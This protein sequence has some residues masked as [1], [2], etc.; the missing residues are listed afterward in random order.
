MDRTII[1]ILLLGACV[2]PQ[3]K[4]QHPH[5]PPPDQTITVMAW[6]IWHGGREDGEHVGVQ[7]T[8]DV[9]R[10]SGADLVAMQ[11][12]YGS[13][14]IIS[15]ALGFHFVPRGTNVSIHSRFPVLADVSVFEE[16]KCVGAVVELP[17]GTPLAFYSIWLPYSEDIWLPE[18]RAKCD[19]DRMLAACQVS[20]DDLK[21]IL[22]LMQAKLHETGYSNIPVIVA[23]DFNSMSHLDYTPAAADQFDGWV[24]NWPTSHVIHDGGFADSYRAVHPTVNRLRDRTWSPRFTEQEQERIDF[25]YYRGD[26]SPTTAQVV[27]THANGFPSDHAAVVTDFTLQRR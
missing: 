26:L 18:I 24:L 22:G 13:G 20:A 1:L 11:E 17:D 19:E 6:N 5:Q 12:T 10:D 14:E 3:A 25:I 8:I 27:Q 4:P 7:K 2:Q 16:F 23:G 21:E 15:H 9:I